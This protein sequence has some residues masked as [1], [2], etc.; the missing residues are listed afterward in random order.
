M[1]V[2]NKRCTKI[3]ITN[4]PRVLRAN[5]SGAATYGICPQDPWRIFYWNFFA[6]VVLCAF[7]AALCGQ[8]PDFEIEEHFFLKDISVCREGGKDF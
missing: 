6:S 7:S 8:K 4:S 2:S 1:R 3:P 5:S